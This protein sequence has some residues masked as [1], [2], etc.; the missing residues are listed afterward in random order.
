MATL[1]SSFGLGKVWREVFL[2]RGLIE[3]DYH[4]ISL[5]SRTILLGREG[6]AAPTKRIAIGRLI[7]ST[8]NAELEEGARAIEGAFSAANN[9]HRNWRRSVYTQ[10][11]AAS[12]DD[13]KKA[14]GVFCFYAAHINTTAAARL[15]KR[16]KAENL[17][18]LASIISKPSAWLERTILELGV[19]PPP[20]HFRC[21]TTRGSMPIVQGYVLDIEDVN[22]NPEVSVFK[23]MEFD[24]NL[25]AE[26]KCGKAVS[27]LLAG[28]VGLQA[29][30]LPVESRIGLLECLRAHHSAQ[31]RGRR[32]RVLDQAKDLTASNQP[33]IIRCFD[34]WFPPP[35]R[36]G[37][38]VFI[39]S[40]GM[41]YEDKIVDIFDRGYAG[42]R[43]KLVSGDSVSIGPSYKPSIFDVVKVYRS[44]NSGECKLY[45]E[46][47]QERGE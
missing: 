35:C 8:S 3:S 9:S 18:S 6:S 26:I 31:E 1:D 36:F 5:S 13:C 37:M 25:Y 42:K 11:I 23:R 2:S 4:P 30:W 40:R 32:W 43:C 47:N 45:S 20:D 22:S 44:P 34:E 46:F 24:S 38:D 19:F 21:I 17:R 7:D 12:L 27:M 14:I 29:G 28:E 33:K 10:E 16:L 41:I 15:C 39:P